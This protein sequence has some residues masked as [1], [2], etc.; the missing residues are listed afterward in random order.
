MNGMLAT[1]S[2]SAIVLWLY[3]LV[4]CSVLVWPSAVW[5]ASILNAESSHEIIS[6]ET[7]YSA[8]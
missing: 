4:Y 2:D 3:F 5:K 6:S 7:A 8:L 1:A